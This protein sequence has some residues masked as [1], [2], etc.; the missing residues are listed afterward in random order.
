MTTWEN[1]EQETDYLDTLRA[2]MASNG[3]ISAMAARLHVHNNTVRYRI[4]RLAKDFALD[5]DDPQKR[6]WLWLRLTTMD[7]AVEAQ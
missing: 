7:L 6:L 5:L 2:Y 1:A 4:S 3:N